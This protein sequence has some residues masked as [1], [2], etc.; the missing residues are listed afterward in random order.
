LSQ[1]DKIEWK[2]AIA[3]GLVAPSGLKPD[4]T[5]QLHLERDMHTAV[6]MRHPTFQG[7][8]VLLRKLDL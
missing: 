7:C 6:S 3:V 1:P 5:R 4:D 8:A 2:I